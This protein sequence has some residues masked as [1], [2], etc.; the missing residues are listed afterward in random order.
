VSAFILLMQNQEVYLP[1]G[2]MITISLGLKPDV[3]DLSS[4]NHCHSLRLGS[5]G[6]NE[7]LTTSTSLVPV[8]STVVVSE[9]VWATFSSA[10][11]TVVMEADTFTTLCKPR[12]ITNSNVAKNLRRGVGYIAVVPW[13]DFIDGK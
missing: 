13:G 8:L 1:P 7:L 4:M 6:N 11:V 10:R 5:P 3:E 9:A 12:V 2:R